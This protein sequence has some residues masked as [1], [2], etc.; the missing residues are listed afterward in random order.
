ML[1]MMREN[2][3]SWIIKILLGIVVLVFIFLGIGPERT[4]NDTVAAM[5]NKK[6]ISMDEY[7][8][9][10][11]NALQMYRSRLGDN[12]NNDILKMLRLEENTLEGLIDRE[13]ILQEADKLGIV[14]TDEEI[15]NE[16]KEIP[17]FQENG[18]FSQTNYMNYIRHYANNSP[19]FFESMQREELLVQK[20]RNLFDNTALVT[21]DEVKAW[22]IWEKKTAQIDYVLFEA[23]SKEE[24]KPTDDEL[25]SYYDGHKDQYMS[26]PQAKVSAIRF[27]PDD[28]KKGITLTDEEISNYYNNNLSKYETPKTVE[29]RH[30]LIKVDENATED[31]VAER[32]LKA[33]QVY[34]MAIKEGQDFAELAK[35]YSE[36]PTKDNG[37]YLGT[38][39]E[40]KMVKP[41]SDKAFS[42][43]EGEI[44]EP[45]RTQ[46][47]W[48]IIKVEKVNPAVKRQLAEAKPEIEQALIKERAENKAYE[49][50]YMVYDGIISGN[51]MEQSS[52]ISGRPIVT[53]DWFTKAAGPQEMDAAIRRD[54]SQKVFDMEEKGISDILELGGSY[55]IVQVTGKKDSDVQ[56]L[57]DVKDRVEKD[58]AKQLKEEKAKEAA[59]A[60]IASIK[61]GKTT[62]AATEGVKE[63]KAFTRES[64]GSELGIEAPVVQ[65][66][67]ALTAEASLSQ[68][69]VKGSKGYYVL[70]LKETKEPDMTL[71]DKEKTR[72]HDKLKQDKQ[73]QAYNLWIDQLKAKSEIERNQAIMRQ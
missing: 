44:S 29:A 66:A 20:F 67:F 53:T 24:V 62:L 68:D 23:N 14:V 17:L 70:Q 51:T 50:V 27:N 4:N 34:E 73:T 71:L 37:G 59:S 6:I 56:P 40:G 35:T 21:D 1:R 28:Y 30:I 41:F 61:E 43:K 49:D 48:H 52:E 8:Y 18:H 3:G 36:G 9:R 42:M 7:R 72:I 22:F 46:F 69:P 45:V 2:A 26:Q 58:L 55:Y 57:A 63:T 32:E 11:N 12:F 64:R 60:L 15:Q 5:V 19:A 31:V 10:Y 16:I 13:L 65:A 25:Q 33:R 54:L 47:G 38:F 39:E